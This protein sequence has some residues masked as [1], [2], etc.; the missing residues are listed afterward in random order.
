MKL[1]LSPLFW[2][3]GNFSSVIGNI[4]F[5][6]IVLIG[7]HALILPLMSCALKRGVLASVTDSLCIQTLWTLP[8]GH[9]DTVYVM[10]RTFYFCLYVGAGF[11][12][13]ILMAKSMCCM[14]YAFVC[15]FASFVCC[16]GD[17]WLTT[18]WCLE[19]ALCILPNTC[20]SFTPHWRAV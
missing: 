2:E 6:S 12:S 3:C 15:L 5:T 18:S 19:Q 20:F 17:P 4:C 9:T 16:A 13:I 11:V 10:L 7:V 8:H 1:S 14:V